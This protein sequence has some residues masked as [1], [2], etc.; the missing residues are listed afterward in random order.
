MTAQTTVYAV[1]LY[2][3]TDYSLCQ[4]LVRLHRLQFMPL[5][6]SSRLVGGELTCSTTVGVMCRLRFHANSLQQYVRLVQFAKRSHLFCVTVKFARRSH[7]SV[8]QWTLPEGR[9]H[10]RDGEVCYIFTDDCER[11]LNFTANR[12][13]SHCAI[14]SRL[15]AKHW[16]AP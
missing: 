8:K 1:L 11:R 4:S 15:F 2:D 16:S 6:H 10:L 7:S 12:E 5:F 13:T 14:A 3:C 9:S